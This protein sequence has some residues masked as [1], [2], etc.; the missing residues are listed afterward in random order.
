[1][2]EILQYWWNKWKGTWNKSKADQGAS[3]SQ[4]FTAFFQI[5]IR[6]TFWKTAMNHFDG[7]TSE[8]E[9]PLS[10]DIAWLSL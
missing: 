9:S 10:K 6:T 8:L 4:T 7:Y 1:M 5:Q 2:H 3:C